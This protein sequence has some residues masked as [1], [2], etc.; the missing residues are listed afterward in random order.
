MNHLG[1]ICKGFR[2]IIVCNSL[3]QPHSPL[4]GGRWEKKSTRIEQYNGH[5]NNV[6]G[7]FPIDNIAGH[8]VSSPWW[9]IQSA[10]KEKRK[11]SI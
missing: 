3:N 7:F 9:A 1:D 4:E 11:K 5:S 2:G 10:E 6:D 8:A